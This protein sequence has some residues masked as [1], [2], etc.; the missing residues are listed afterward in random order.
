MTTSDETEVIAKEATAED[1]KEAPTNMIVGLL[2]R[3]G[4]KT[5]I[6][7]NGIIAALRLEGIEGT[8]GVHV[9]IVFIVDWDLGAFT[10]TKMGT[11]AVLLE[12]VNRSTDSI[13]RDFGYGDRYCTISKRTLKGNVCIDTLCPDLGKQG[14]VIH[15]TRTV[16]VVYEE[17]R[18]G[19]D[20]SWLT[21]EARILPKEDFIVARESDIR[22][23][24]PEVQRRVAEEKWTFLS[25]GLVFLYGM[26]FASVFTISSLVG[27]LVAFI[28][29]NGIMI[30]L[31]GLVVGAVLSLGTAYLSI[32]HISQFNRDLESERQSLSKIGDTAR[33]EASASTS[34]DTL[35]LLRDLSFVVSPLMAEVGGAIRIGD[36]EGAAETAN[37][38]IDEVVRLSPH[39]VKMGDEG[40]SKF[41]GMFTSQDPE[42]DV[43]ELSLCYSS[44]TGHITN[45]LSEEDVLRNCTVLLNSLHRIGGVRTEVKETVD[46]MMNERSMKAALAEIRKEMDVPV[47]EEPSQ[48]DLPVGADDADINLLKEMDKEAEEITPDEPSEVVET[49]K[50]ALDTAHP[51]TKDHPHSEEDDTAASDQPDSGEVIDFVEVEAVTVETIEVTPSVEITAADVID[52]SKKEAVMY[53]NS[54]RD[55]SRPERRRKAKSAA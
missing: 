7:S 37:L 10:G 15:A 6:Y 30:P 23:H 39:S 54:G 46:N 53:A 11:Q 21:E 34:K 41:I 9:D 28:N 13:L 8:R 55:N 26:A 33:V 40:I 49:A 20:L 27:L 50:D 22:S 12:I 19:M 4:H 24:R 25:R 14:S 38:I 48:E 3:T 51:E 31:A 29:A 17:R 16:Y 47:Q 52:Q 32:T 45:P 35:D 1:E 2:E 36:T 44:L 42:C 18:P 43:G 5:H